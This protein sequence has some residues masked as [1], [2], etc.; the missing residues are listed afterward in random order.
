MNGETFFCPNCGPQDDPLGNGHGCCPICSMELVRI[1]PPVYPV[2][3]TDGI[4]R[5]FAEVERA[6]R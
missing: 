1:K 6:G 3:V 2:Q 5:H 4:T